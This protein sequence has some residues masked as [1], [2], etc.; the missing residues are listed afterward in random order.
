MEILLFPVKLGPKKCL[1]LG[2]FAGALSASCGYRPAAMVSAF[3]GRLSVAAAPFTTPYPEA[4]AEAM[5]GARDELSSAGVLGA[6]RFPRLVVEVVRVDELPAGITAP[7]GQGPMA[8]G[9][10]VGVTARGWIE[11]REGVPPEND[12]GDVRRLETVLQGSD[13]VGAGTSALEAV[14]AAAREAGRA[15]A[16]RAL[17][18]AEPA[19]EPM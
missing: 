13:P 7:R 9:S 11:E 15:V 17:G 12:T 3:D 8:R 6:G 4:A 18:L 16:R 19:I 1:V 2:A 14:H 10:D 5:S